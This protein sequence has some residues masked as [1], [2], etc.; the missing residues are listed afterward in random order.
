MTYYLALACFVGSWVSICARDLILVCGRPEFYDAAKV[1]PLI[2]LS[3]IVFGCH[4]HVNTGIMIAKKT[5]YLMYINLCN[6]LLNVALNLLLIPRYGM[7]G[8]AYSTL[9]CFINKVAWT[10][11]VSNKLYPLTYEYGRLFKVFFAAAAVFLVGSVI[12]YPDVYHEYLGDVATHSR[13]LRLMGVR[14]F[15][16]HSCAMI[17]FPGILLLTRFTLPQEK[18]YVRLVVQRVRRSVVGRFTSK[19][20]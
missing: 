10:R 18:E 20:I 2:T 11:W 1:V 16:I 9:V 19:D 4:Y 5:Q 15:L 8:A 6:A 13:D 14:F 17:L 3:Y 12:R 7:Y